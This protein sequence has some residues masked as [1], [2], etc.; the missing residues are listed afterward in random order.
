[1]TSGPPTGKVVEL[2][3]LDGGT[4]RPE[5]IRVL[6]ILRGIAQKRIAALATQLFGGVDDA[7]FDLAER[8]NNNQA[9]ARFFDGM[10]E[11]RRKRQQA[12]AQLQEQIARNL[13]DFEAGRV[14]PTAEEAL[15][16]TSQRGKDELALVDEAELEETLAINAMVDKTDTR[17]NRQ[18]YALNQRFGA[19]LGGRK[20]D[21]ANNPIGPKLLSRAFG[22]AVREFEVD[23]QVKL[24]V[25]K[26]FERHVLAGLDQLY[27]EAN[28]L[29]IQAGVLPEL[30][31]QV[32]VSRRADAR[33][34]TPGSSEDK[35][36]SAAE[37]ALQ[38]ASQALSEAID[39][40]SASHTDVEIMSLVGELRGLLSARRGPSVGASTGGARGAGGNVATPSPRELLNALSLMQS[41]L[42]AHQQAGNIDPLQVKQ[43]LISQVRQL[44]GHAGQAT[45]L[46]SDEDTIDLVGMLFEYALQDRNLPAPMQALLGRLQIP[47]LKVALMD[48]E[49]I[50]QR[51]HPARRLLDELAH[52][53]VGWS[54]DSDRDRRLYGKIQEIVNTLLK[55]FDDDTGIFEKL[56]HDFNEF[57]DKNRKRSELVER[58]TSEAAR[59]RERL[60]SAQ[61]TA[62]RAILSKIA[63]RNL[64]AGVRDL[65]TRRWSN[66]LVLTY[67]RHGEESTEWRNANRLIEDLAWSV[68]P[69][70]DPNEQLRL[71]ERTPEIENLLRQGLAATG[72][73]ESHLDELW[74]EI[75]QIY[76]HQV[77]PHPHTDA[78]GAATT[79]DED[80]QALTI[81]FAS[82]KAGEEIVF[83]DDMAESVDTVDVD[84][85]TLQAL[86]TWLKIARALKAG[87]WFEFIKD[88]GSRER[89]K[90]LWIST[91]RALYL[92]VNRN[93]IKIAEKTAN[94]LAEELKDQRAVILE[95]V[96]LVDRA[97]DAIL[98]RLREN[99]GG[100]G[101]EGAIAEATPPTDTPTAAPINRAA[102]PATP[103]SGTNAAA[104]RAEAA[105]SP[106]G[107]TSAVP[108][109]ATAAPAA[110]T[111]RPQAPTAAPTAT[112]PVAPAPR[113][114]TPG[115][116]P[117]RPAEAA[118]PSAR[119]APSTPDP[120][121][122]GNA[123]T[124]SPQVPP[125]A[126][127]G[128][129]PRPAGATP[130]AATPRPAMPG[131]PTATPRP[132][133][134]T[135]TP[136]GAARPAAAT[137]ATAKPATPTAPGLTAARPTTPGQANPP[138]SGAN[139]PRPNAANDP[140][141]PPRQ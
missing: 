76:D 44:G 120:M 9:Q 53:C 79:E 139:N 112:R 130:T 99:E 74:N 50:A 54:E 83:R 95:Q 20:I 90:L 58:R 78:A 35:A 106:I 60:E 15:S 128:L 94:E 38:E 113:P 96:A 91:I 8:A 3:R 117:T 48:R 134:P 62:A 34:A 86:D 2:N 45:H 135:A 1:M 37:S 63:G 129:P 107:A 77:G 140:K 87:T 109:P 56:S 36:S 51:S 122:S 110:A 125:R 102:A 101:E 131:A 127:P 18:I 136:P 40:P 30:R 88:D 41:E 22:H 137:P 108:R 80:A 6:P 39:A 64:P 26:L 116:T 100:T 43:S 68:E 59:G 73:H 42:T 47:Y 16:E 21:N 12:E 24:I 82:S 67:L 66:Y 72:L 49:F 10:R 89:A 27:D 25:L 126:A 105:P 138:A 46:G 33:P 85:A 57:I 31:Y 17:L 7:L 121:R 132:A 115:V 4:V 119:P 118:A 81:R 141:S 133:A 123:P 19:L 98:T 103:Q 69:K 29:L 14:A 75:K 5:A 97:L 124:A 71:R 114:A 61:R 55:D 84:A 11:V 65:L 93:G 111:A 70:H 32:S 28:L 23:L 104:P 13:A 92:F 52:S